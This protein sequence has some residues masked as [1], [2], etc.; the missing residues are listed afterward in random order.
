M[1]EFSYNKARYRSL[2]KE[3]RCVSCKTYVD[4]GKSRC[5]VCMKA[6]E[7]SVKK[8]KRKRLSDMDR[9]IKELEAMLA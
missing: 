5:P 7:E 4:S 9:R 2:R 8:S 1:E 3:G 6:L